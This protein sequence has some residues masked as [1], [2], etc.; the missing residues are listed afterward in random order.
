MCDVSIITFV[1]LSTAVRF[2]Q[3]QSY[4]IYHFKVSAVDLL[5]SCVDVAF[6]LQFRGAAVLEMECNI[7]ACRVLALQKV[8][9][10]T[11]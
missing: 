3:A 7:K 8:R 1:Y 9:N 4:A 6:M 5:E 11:A 2:T 10:C